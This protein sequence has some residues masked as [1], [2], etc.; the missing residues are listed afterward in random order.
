MPVAPRCIEVYADMIDCMDQGYGRLV[1]KHQGPWEL[2]DMT[3]DRTRMNNLAAQQ[4][5]R[6]KEMSAQW[7]ARA[8]RVGVLPWPLGGGEGKK[9]TGKAK[10]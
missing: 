8:K 9:G 1:S 2:Y 6:V 3:T 4:P 5:D 10:K 7:D